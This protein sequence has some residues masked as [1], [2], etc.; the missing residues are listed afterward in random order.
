MYKR[1][2]HT[3]PVTDVCI[4]SFGIRARFATVSSDHTCRVYDL[5]TGNPLLSLVFDE[6]LTTALFDMPGWNLYVGCNSGCIQQINLLKQDVENNK[7]RFLGHTDRVNCLDVSFTGQLL[8]SGA[9]DGKVC[10]WD[11]QRRQVLRIIEEKGPV[12]N[13]KLVFSCK[14]MFAHTQKPSMVVRPLTRSLELK[15]SGEYEV[16]VIQNRDAEFDG[17][18][19]IESKRNNVIEERLAYSNVANELLINR[20]HKS[21]VEG[22]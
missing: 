11:I 14:N 1:M 9:N 18:G 6:A 5:L 15:N 12:T 17:D 21:F 8:V 7:L 3:M 16:G 10:V 22:A 2:D 13:L 4:G 19:V 20:L